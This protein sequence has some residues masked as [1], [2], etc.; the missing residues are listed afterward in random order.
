VLEAGAV[1]PAEVYE[2]LCQVR[3]LGPWTAGYIVQRALGAPDVFLATD[4]AVRRAA[5]QLGLPD[6]PVALAEAAEAWTPWRSYAM[7]HLWS[8]LRS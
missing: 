5:R 7:H 8:T 1:D 2:Q 4:L 3:G 6:D